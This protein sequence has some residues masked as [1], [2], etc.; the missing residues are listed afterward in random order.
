MSH[1]TK[2]AVTANHAT[3]G[4]VSPYSYQVKG[5]KLATEKFVVWKG[6]ARLSRLTKG[7]GKGDAPRFY[8]YFMDGDFQHWIELPES[9]YTLLAT[10][11]TQILTL[12]TV[13]AP[14]PTEAPAQVE[15]PATAPK[16]SRK[17]K[18][19]AVEA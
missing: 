3:I 11:K 16:A 18:R 12:E 7:Q 5:K 6:E 17:A 10:D 14:A 19:E 15:A 1:T 8:A 2:I 4:L 9:T 13:A